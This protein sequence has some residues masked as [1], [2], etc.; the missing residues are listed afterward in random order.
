MVGDVGPIDDGL[1]AEGVEVGGGFDADGDDAELVEADDGGSSAHASPGVVATAPP[2][3]SATAR[4]PT[5]P[6]YLE[7]D[8]F[9]VALKLCDAEGLS[10]LVVGSESSRRVR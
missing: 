1:D 8:V 7:C 6:M 3:P 10:L 2:T 5:R 9:T 4:A